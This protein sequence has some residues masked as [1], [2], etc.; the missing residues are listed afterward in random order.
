MEEP[1]E[2]NLSDFGVEPQPMCDVL[3]AICMTYY[4]TRCD[5]GIRQTQIIVTNLIRLIIETGTVTAAAALVSLIHF[6]AFPR[7][8]LDGTTA[9]IIPKLYANTIYI[10]LN[11][12]F[13][14]MGGRD[15]YTSRIDMSI[16][17]STGDI[18]FESMQGTPPADVMQEQVSVIVISK[19]AFDNGSNECQ[20]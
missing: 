3:I 20:S 16:T 2:R 18:T 10:V 4:L 13:R 9:F 17:T 7:Q 19:E 15:T 12:R 1:A 6:F 5:P 14:M 11:S 8:A